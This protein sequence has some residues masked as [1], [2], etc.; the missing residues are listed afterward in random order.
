MTGNSAGSRGGGAFEC[1]TRNCLVTGNTAAMGG[2][3]AGG[4]GV[5]CTVAYNAAQFGGGVYTGAFTNC[6][7]Y[8]NTADTDSNWYV[9]SYYHCCTLPMPSIGFG[10][11]TDEPLFLD[12]AGGNF[13]LQP[14]SPC[15]NAGRNTGLPAGPDLDGN[16]R[17]VGG[18]V[19]IGA[20]EFQSPSSVLSY[21]WAQQ[22]GLPTDGSADYTDP[23]GDGMNNWQEWKCDTVP[24]NAA[25][26]LRLLSPAIGESGVTI[27]WQSVTTRRYFVERVRELG[28]QPAFSVLKTNIIGQAGTTS[29]TDTTATNGGPYFYR[30]GV[31][32]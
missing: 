24:T 30:V 15:I 18:T 21:A 3:L 28:T 12:A 25:S 27:T 4:N 10:T 16:P 11:I 1:T 2:G 22:Y 17:I 32:Q 14:L 20:Y 5:N 29:Y 23:D 26:V 19:D 13:R 31:H 9:G 7:V 6:I 8:Y